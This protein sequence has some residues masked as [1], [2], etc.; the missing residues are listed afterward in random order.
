MYRDESVER[1]DL[2]EGVQSF[3][4]KRPPNFAPLEAKE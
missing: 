3:K 1:S 4:G 2:A